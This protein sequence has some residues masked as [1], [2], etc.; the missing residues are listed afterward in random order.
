METDLEPVCFTKQQKKK[1]L[2][3]NWFVKWVTSE[4]SEWYKIDL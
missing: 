1:F 4:D 2:A 3:S